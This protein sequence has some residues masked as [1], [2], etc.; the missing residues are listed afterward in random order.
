MCF[1]RYEHEFIQEIVK[2][3]ST[4]LQHEQLDIGEQIIG[5]QSPI[6]DIKSLLDIES[7]TVCMLGIH[8]TGGMGKTTVA[9]GLYN[10][11]VHLFE[12]AIFLE[13]IR[14]RSNCYM[15]LVH[16]QE[17]ILSKLF[18]GENI[19]LGGVCEGASRIKDTF[20][21]KS[22]LLVLDDVDSED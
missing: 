2:K 4:K 22:V 10:S 6:E 3:A 8:G 16:L 13:S 18:E 11:I 17:T 7:Y 20:Q 15:G 19:K 14:E 21:N 9:K 12:F 1:C 5:H